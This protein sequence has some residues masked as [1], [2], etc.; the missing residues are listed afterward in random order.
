MKAKSTKSISDAEIRQLVVARLRS[1]PSNRKISIGSAG[2]F[3]KDEL[4]ERVEKQDQIGKKIIAVQLEY[5]RALKEGFLL[6]AV[7]WT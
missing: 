3:S 7:P 5:L 6:P 1:L 4:I 2:E